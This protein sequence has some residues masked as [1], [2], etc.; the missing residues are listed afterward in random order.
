M[1]QKQSQWKTSTGFILA[2]AGSAIGLGA[3]WKFPYMAGIYGGGAFLFMFLLFTLIV[4]LPLLIMEFAIGKMG[5]TYTTKIYEKL[6]NKKWLN[7]IGWNGNLAVFILF[8]FYSVIGGWIVIYLAHVFMQILGFEQGPLGHIQFEQVIGNPW[9]TI[10]G[11]G[12]IR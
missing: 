6:T 1:M 12:V 11:Q 9:I 5:R 2:S 8:G 7:I 10:I 4:G 3:M